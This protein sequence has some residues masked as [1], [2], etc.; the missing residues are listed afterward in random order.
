MGAA[1]MFT[2]STRS[3]SFTR[4][5]YKKSHQYCIPSVTSGVV[6][7]DERSSGRT[8][9]QFPVFARDDGDM[10]THAYS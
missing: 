9:H 6:V 7:C 4:E 5:Y 1:K 8:D 3:L 10:L 2:L